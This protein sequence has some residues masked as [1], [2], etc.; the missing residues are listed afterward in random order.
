MLTSSSASIASEGIKIA[1]RACI[2]LNDI[3]IDIQDNILD[4]P[5]SGYSDFLKVDITTAAGAM[6]V[7]KI[8]QDLT[9]AVQVA[10][11]L[12]AATNKMQQ[13]VIRTLGS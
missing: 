12:L 6:A 11:Q 1:E 10:A 9:T 13:I 8:I 5:P 7:D 3:I 2:S 4:H